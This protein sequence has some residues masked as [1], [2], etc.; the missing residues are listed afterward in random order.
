[1]YKNIYFI[2]TGCTSEICT[3]ITLKL[4]KIK[5]FKP[6]PEI[7]ARQAKPSTLAGLSR[8]HRSSERTFAAV[9]M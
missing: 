3:P 6:Q 9:L 7:E 8:Y 2:T 5:T 4:L 1:M